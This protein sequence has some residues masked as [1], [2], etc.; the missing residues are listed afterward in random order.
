M[1]VHS[2][3]RDADFLVRDAGLYCSMPEERYEK[4]AHEN[5][6]ARLDSNQRRRKVERFTVGFP[7]THQLKAAFIGTI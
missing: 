1:R 5:D 2:R 6:G 7:S 4:D 3:Y